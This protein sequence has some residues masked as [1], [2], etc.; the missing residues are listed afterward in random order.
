LQPEQ[1]VPHEFLLVFALEGEQVL[2][3]ELL[4]FVPP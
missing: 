1:E 3:H 2:H 4:V